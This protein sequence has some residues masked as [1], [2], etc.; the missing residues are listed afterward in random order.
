MAIRHALPV[1][2]RAVLA[3]SLAPAVHALSTSADV[4]ALSAGL[5]A[6]LPLGLTLWFLAS[7]GQILVGNPGIFLKKHGRRHAVTGLLY[8]AWILLGLADL[9]LSA[10]YAHGQEGSDDTGSALVPYL[11]YDVV[12]GVLGTALTLTA[13]LEFQHKGVKN[14]ASGTLDEHATVTHG[15]MIEH[16]FYQGLNLVQVI[17]I[18]AMALVPLSADG[19]DHAGYD[20]IRRE[21]TFYHSTIHYHN[22]LPRL[23]L[24]LAATAPW[25]LRDR[26]PINR[27][28]DN[29]TKIDPKS[30]ALV[31]LLYRIKK[32]QYVFYKHF[33]LHGLNITIALTGLALGSTRFFR[34]YW[35]LLNISYVMEFF[36]QTLVKKKF[37]AQ[38]QL[39]WLQK[40]LMTAATLGTL[41]ILARTNAG[42]ALGSLAANFANRRHDLANTALVCALALGAAQ[43]FAAP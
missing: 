4:P 20:R 33:L 34:L 2:A 38:S 41:P 16:S 19:D 42:V 7:L 21:N 9:A 15:E 43:V 3:L 40:V 36:L 14:V 8:L 25:L 31:R 35:L 39:L 6:L 1:P 23:A 24:L 5:A 27:F 12:L 10:R 32:Y 13:A 30:T 28:S 22:L 29:Y 26:F 37:M 17:F 18:H 11:L